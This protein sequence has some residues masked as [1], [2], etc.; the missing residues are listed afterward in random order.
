MS[1][2]AAFM[3]P[4]PPLIVPAIGG[5][6][7]EEVR[8]TIRSYEQVAEEIA[9]LRPETV[10]ITSPHATMYADYFHI[11][12]GTGAKGSFSDFGAPQVSFEESYDGVLRDRICQIAD[13]F[14]VQSVRWMKACTGTGKDSEETYAAGN[15]SPADFGYTD[16]RHFW[17]PRKAKHVKSMENHM[18]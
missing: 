8:E 4:H 3:V 6:R 2:Q 7:E 18:D 9:K 5:G 12:P 14:P 17:Q 10:I 11:S 15:A 1:I 13:V 16:T